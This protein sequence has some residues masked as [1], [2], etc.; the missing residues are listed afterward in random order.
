MNLLF[1]AAAIGSR[2]S[3]KTCGTARKNKQKRQQRAKA[4]VMASLCFADYCPDF[5]L[6]VK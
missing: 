4:E 6:G 3:K 5:K 1:C 2:A